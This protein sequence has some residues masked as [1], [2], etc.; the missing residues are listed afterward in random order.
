MTQTLARPLIALDGS[1]ASAVT[2][3][4]L[5]PWLERAE[6][7]V[8]LHVVDPDPSPS[9]LFDDDHESL[10]LHGEERGGAAARAYL[11]RAA[12]GTDLAERASCVVEAGKIAE[13]I[14]ES[15]S[16]E[17][18][19]MIAMATHG[20]HGLARWTLGSQTA[21]VLRESTVPVVVVPSGHRTTAPLPAA[22]RHVLVP[23]D[24][25]ER[26]LA[27]VPHVQCLTDMGKVRVTLIH[28]VPRG[29]SAA[30]TDRAETHLFRARYVFEDAGMLPRTRIVRAP[31]ALG[32]VEYALPAAD[33]D[34]PIDLI[35][36]TTHGRS[37]VKRWALGSVTERVIQHTNLPLMVVRSQLAD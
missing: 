17:K 32:I 29:A 12:K 15:A 21:R 6:S 30:D 20:R 22:V 5:R 35:A 13:T 1:E 10:Y 4:Y 28:C 36:M 18:A 27:L 7:F 9:V 24:G 34:I 16:R 31:A 37:G 19:T 26:A 11:E 3:A 23:I 33:D 25:S 8:L 14:L 2:L